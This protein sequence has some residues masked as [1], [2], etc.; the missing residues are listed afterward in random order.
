MSEQPIIPPEDIVPEEVN[1]MDDEIPQVLLQDEEPAQ[2]SEEKTT[3]PKISTDFIATLNGKMVLGV[4][5]IVIGGL[6]ILGQIFNFRV[7][8]LLWPFSIILPGGFLLML[9]LS[10]KTNDEALSIIGSLI[11][12]TGL[13]LLYQNVTGHWASWAYAWSLIA[14]TS[15]GV[16]LW[17]F[18]KVK[19]RQS[20]I[21]SGKGVMR[22]GLII[23]AV[24]AV[25]FELIIGISR[26]GRGLGAGIL[27][28]VGIYML[29][30]SFRK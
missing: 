2:K 25:F 16:G 26:F 4:G 29:A 22:V 27:V 19:S 13:L 6:M 24:G 12:A 3:G 28:L 8:S 11:S 1:D 10:E 17:L 9:G 20:Q 14:P 30:R 18:G 21:D 5:L 23:F 15:V 7:G